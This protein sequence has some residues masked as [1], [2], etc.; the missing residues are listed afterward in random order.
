MNLARFD[1]LTLSVFVAVARHGSISAGARH[2]NLAVAAASKRISDLEAAVGTPLLFRH[3][4][5]VELTEAGQTCF[6]HAI[7]ILEDVERMAG[8]MSDYATGARGQVRIWANTSAITQFLADDLAI[9]LRE[10]PTIRVEV[11]EHNSNDIVSALIENRA[12]I[13]IFADRTPSSTLVTLPYREDELV[14]VAPPGHPLTEFDAVDFADTLA[15]DFVGLSRNTSLAARLLEES[16]RIE[17]TIPLR[18][19]V[20]SFDAICRMVRAGL[21]V[22]I[23]PRIA[24]EPHAQAMQLR[25]VPLRDAWARR[26][27]QVGVR[28]AQALTVSSRLL[29]THLC[30]P[31]SPFA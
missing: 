18:I 19:Q 24:A 9:F 30:G 17:R 28:D 8:V 29:V 27:L 26:M 1:L 31:Y 15:Y 11:E 22:G 23:L 6:R 2:S 3:A 20:H 25:I 16:S 5:G 4:T 13:G 14:V 10:H 12:D 7:V 21:A